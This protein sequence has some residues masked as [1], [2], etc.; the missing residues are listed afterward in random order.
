MFFGV[1]L[2]FQQV[3]RNSVT[4]AVFVL[5]LYVIVHVE[6]TVLFHRA[7]ATNKQKNYAV[8]VNTFF[9]AKQQRHQL[10]CVLSHPCFVIFVLLKS[11]TAK[12]GNQF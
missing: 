11:Q 4:K 2:F 3:N 1:I 7:S 10:N 9:W 6:K 8:L 5:H 12:K